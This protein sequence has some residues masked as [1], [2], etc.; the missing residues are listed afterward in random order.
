[1]AAPNGGYILAGAHNI[2]ADTLAENIYAMFEA[3]KTYGVYPIKA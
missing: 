3:A 1:M 2:Q